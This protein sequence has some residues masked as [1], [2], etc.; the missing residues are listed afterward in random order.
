MRAN[1]IRIAT[2]FVLLCAFGAQFA[3]AQDKALD[4]SPRSQGEMD[5]AIYRAELN[6]LSTAVEHLGSDLEKVE[7][8]RRSLLESWVVRTGETRYEVR[9]AWLDAALESYARDPASRDTRKKEV[10]ARIQ[11][12]LDHAAALE[13]IT[14][15]TGGAPARTALENILKRPEFHAEAKETWWDRAQAAF[16]RWLGRILRNIFGRVRRIAPGGNVFIWVV[17]GIAFLL[18]VLAG[19]KMLLRA[20]RSESLRIGTPRPDGKT[21]NEWAQEAIRAAAKGDYRQAMHA[22]YWAGVFRL[23]DLGVWELSRSRTPREY[24][25]LLEEHKLP[26][27]AQPEASGS[28]TAALASLTRRFEVTW[29]GYEAATEVDFREALS[30]LE[31]LG[32]RF[33]SSLATAKS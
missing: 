27:A 14:A 17:I 2:L 29:Y 33:P 20:A 19:R 21:W 24:L 7:S 13:K 28:R 18:L 23:A 1:L 4:V 12:L 10:H 8:L 25:R 30:Q 11:A 31:A 3:A 32:C 16:W 22:A 15:E 5:L 9:M 26:L 6:R